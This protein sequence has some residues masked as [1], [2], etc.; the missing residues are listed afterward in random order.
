[1][2]EVSSHHAHFVNRPQ[3]HTG[4]VFRQQHRAVLLERDSDFLSAVFHVNRP[5]TAAPLMRHVAPHLSS[6]HLAYLGRAKV[7]GLTTHRVLGLLGARSEARAAYRRRLRARAT[8]EGSPLQR[9]E[10]AEMHARRRGSFAKSLES[11]LSAQIKSRFVEQAIDAACAALDVRRDEVLSSSRVRR[12]VL[13]RALVA[14][15]VNRA[16]LASYAQI[17]KRLDRDPTT[18]WL[19]AERYR[20]LRPDLFEVSLAE[21]LGT[22]LSA[23]R[24]LPTQWRRGSP[25]AAHQRSSAFSG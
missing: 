21:F 25:S 19:A 5:P 4:H 14:W 8:S 12:L 1:V 11:E 20:R 3:G 16:G 15:Q 6:S 23:G 7:P 13:A 18:L 10:V 24:A 9:R 22:A 2:Q 17:G